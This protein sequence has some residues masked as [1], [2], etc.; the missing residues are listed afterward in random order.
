M[1]EQLAAFC[2]KRGRTMLE[3]AFGWL[4][5]HSHVSSVIAGVTSPE[6][7][8]QNASALGWKLTAEEITAVDRIAAEADKPDF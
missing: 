7:L 5:A 2:A 4:L 6:Q 3:L 8:R 1:I